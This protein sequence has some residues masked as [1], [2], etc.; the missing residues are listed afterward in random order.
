MSLTT[1]ALFRGLLHTGGGFLGF[2]TAA[3]IV[4]PRQIVKCPPAEYV[5]KLVLFAGCLSVTMGVMMA[6]LTI[7]SKAGREVPRTAK[8]LSGDSGRAFLITLGVGLAGAWIA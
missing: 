7:L 2:L 8:T 5:E 3:M 6:L 4:R 1:F